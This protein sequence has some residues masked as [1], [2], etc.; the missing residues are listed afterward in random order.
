ML[1]SIAQSEELLSRNGSDA[2]RVFGVSHVRRQLFAKA[3]IAASR[4]SA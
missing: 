2:T 3:A 1:T 4:V